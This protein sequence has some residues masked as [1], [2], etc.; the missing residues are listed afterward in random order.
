[1]LGVGAFSA[2]NTDSAVC[3]T[4][5]FPGADQSDDCLSAWR[6]MGFSDA[7]KRPLNG[8]VVSKP[9]APVLVL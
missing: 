5:Q 9:K 2:M 8:S 3:H 7:L 4:P 6:T 1:M